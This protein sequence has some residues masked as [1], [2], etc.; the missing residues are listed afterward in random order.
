MTIASRARSTRFRYH[1]NAYQFV[2]AALR[3]TQTQLGRDS[4][5]E[6]DCEEAHISGQ[7]LLEGIRDFAR[8]QYGLLTKTVFQQWGIECTDDFGRIVFEL[9]ERGEMKKTDR[10]QLTDFVDVYD[11]DTAFLHDYVIDTSRAFEC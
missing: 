4:L 5:T 8:S 2:F 11:F 1:P 10:D 6:A 9:I 3:F 7:E